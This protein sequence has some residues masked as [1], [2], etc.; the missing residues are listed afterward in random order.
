MITHR[1]WL[2]VAHTY[3]RVDNKNIKPRRIK[4]IYIIVVFLV[5]GAYYYKPIQK[6]GNIKAEKYC[7]E[8]IKIHLICKEIKL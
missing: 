8:I 4:L 7:L 6:T 2:N 1:I 5:N 3:T